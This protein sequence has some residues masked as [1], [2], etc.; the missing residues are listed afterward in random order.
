MEIAQ[1][2]RAVKSYKAAVFVVSAGLMGLGLMAAVELA[3]YYGRI[4]AQDVSKWIVKSTLGGF[5]VVVDHKKGAVENA[6]K[7]SREQLERNLYF[8]MLQLNAQ[9][10]TLDDLDQRLEL[11][12]NIGAKVI[13]WDHNN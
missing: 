3:T 1:E 2:L 6:A 10:E 9:A 5:D 11:D 4:A 12:K 7:L 8:A 13:R